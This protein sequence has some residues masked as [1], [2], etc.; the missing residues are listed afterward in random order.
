MLNRAEVAG[1][2]GFGVA[3]TTGHWLIVDAGQPWTDTGVTVRRGQTMVFDVEGDIRLS[4][5]P[6]DVARSPGA[7]SGRRAPNAPLPNAPAGALIGRI[8]RSGPFG[9]GNQRSIEAPATGRLY[10]G[11]NDD[12][13]GDNAGQFRV[14]I[15]AR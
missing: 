1:P 13:F 5:D 10:L 15:D 4:P 11:I 14:M 9:I 6:N 3:P 7:L 12:Y 2:G 8:D